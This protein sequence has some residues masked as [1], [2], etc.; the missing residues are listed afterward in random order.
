LRGELERWQ[1][2]LHEYRRAVDDV[3]CLKKA[4]GGVNLD[5]GDIAVAPDVGIEI[6]ET[7]MK[8]VQTELNALEDWAPRHN[9]PRDVWRSQ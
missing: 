2:Q 8:E 1:R 5:E 3:I 7:H 9:I 4:A 6:L